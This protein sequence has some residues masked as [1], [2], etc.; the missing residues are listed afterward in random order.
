MKWP[1][2][3]WW[4]GAG[5]GAALFGCAGGG[6]TYLFRTQ[7]EPARARNEAIQRRHLA[8]FLDD[9][10]YLQ[11]HPFFRVGR[12]GKSDASVYLNSKLT[13]LPSV[14][15]AGPSKAATKPLLSAADREKLLRMRNDWIQHPG[16]FRRTKPD[17]APLKTMLSFDYWDLERA[18]PIEG[19]VARKEFVPPSEL[20]APDSLELTGLVKLR[21]IKAAE[22]EDWLEALKETRHA[23]R[24]MFTTESL[25]MQLAGLALLD[26]ER[27]A[28]RHY[29]EQNMID[30]SA[31][32][33]IDRNFTRRASRALWATRGYLR[34]LTPGDVFGPVFL[35]PGHEPVGLCAAANEAFPIE[36]SLRPL[37]I[38]R[39]PGELDLSD[40]FA[41]LNQVWEKARSACRAR[42]LNALAEGGRFDENLPVPRLFRFLPWSRQLFGGKLSTLNFVGFE[43]YENAAGR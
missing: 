8:E 27:R 36:W 12:E 25:Q 37:L 42:Y 17:F 1:R 13:W 18:S 23:A 24:L 39:W 20:P 19:L 41:R 14:A 21:L 26:S 34:L 9:Q 16:A 22:A 2:G 7:V 30:E 5:I 10:S 4:Y 6:V 40:H 29:V 11:G 31:W 35:Q 28:Y 15:G 38:G 43:A 32:K 3:A 33:P